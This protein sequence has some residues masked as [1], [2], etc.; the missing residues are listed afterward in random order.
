MNLFEVAH[1]LCHRLALREAHNKAYMWG[2]ADHG[3]QHQ[4]RQG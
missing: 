2:A 4:G 3:Q 1:E